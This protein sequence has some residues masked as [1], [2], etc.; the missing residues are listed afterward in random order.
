MGMR[1]DDNT[2]LKR[3]DKRVENVGPVRQRQGPFLGDV[4]VG[5]VKQL[6]NS[7]L[8]GKNRLVFSDLA[9]LAVVGLAAV[10][11]VNQ[12]ADFRREV[13]KAGQFGPMAF[14]GADS[15]GIFIRPFLAPS[16]ESG[17]GLVARGS[18]VNGLQIA[19]KG[20]LVFVDDVFEAARI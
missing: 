13:E 3:D 9:Q 20:V 19:Q 2:I 5:Q 12:P 15:D 11:G 10:V 1:L 17:F 6:A 4:A 16:Q 8:S 7:I 14:P 18:L